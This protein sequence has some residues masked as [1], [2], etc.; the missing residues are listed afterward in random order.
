VSD[1]PR[2]LTILLPL[3][4]GYVND[5]DD[6][7]GATNHGVTQRTYDAWQDAHQRLRRSVKEITDAEVSDLYEANYWVAARCG[8]LPW[9]L[10]GVHFDCAV[11]SGVSA[12]TKQLQRALGLVDDGLFGPRTLQAGQAAGRTEC[13]KYLLERVWF[14]RKLARQVPSTAKFLAGGWL[15]RLERWAKEVG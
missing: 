2:A 4:G 6:S 14:Y 5:P 13:Y 12:A 9:P 10:A 11:N 15:G 3:E 1:F 7:G 8:E